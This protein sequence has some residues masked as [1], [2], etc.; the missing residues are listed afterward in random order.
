MID[1]KLSLGKDF[2]PIIII[3]NAFYIA[4]LCSDHKSYKIDAN[5][6]YN[7]FSN[8]RDLIIYYNYI[9]TGKVIEIDYA[10][11]KVNSA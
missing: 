9:K 6:K 11:D 2:P 10:E 7:G 5:Y 3:D 4:E 1:Q 8:L